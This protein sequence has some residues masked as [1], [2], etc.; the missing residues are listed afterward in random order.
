M[1][2]IFS[3]NVG[4]LASPSLP[5]SF[6][7]PVGTPSQLA[8]VAPSPPAA[9]AL[10]IVSLLKK[11]EPGVSVGWPLAADTFFVD[12]VDGSKLELT[13]LVNPVIAKDN[14]ADVANGDIRSDR[15]FSGSTFF[16]SPTIPSLGL[17]SC[18]GCATEVLPGEGLVRS[19]SFGPN[20]LDKPYVNPDLIESKELLPG[21][22]LP[23]EQ[24][25]M[26]EL[27]VGRGTIREAIKSLV[28]RNIVEIRRGVG[29]FVAEK[30]GGIPE[31]G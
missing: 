28:S 15:D 29:T 3:K 24:E 20:K 14:P 26:K 23:S 4:A 7:S 25:L 31:R 22:R 27:S 13:R 21:E 6:F 1:F 5:G 19:T 11:E 9:N 18:G 12:F 17:A 2:A 10:K 30:T 8:K 16:S